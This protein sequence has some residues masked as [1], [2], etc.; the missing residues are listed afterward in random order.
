MDPRERLLFR[1]QGLHDVFWTAL[2]AS[3]LSFTLFFF[4]G[5]DNRFV[6]VTMHMVLDDLQGGLA[7]AN[8][9]WRF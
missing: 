8:R 5:A 9:K 1:Q 3:S 2:L 4:F 6:G 7:C